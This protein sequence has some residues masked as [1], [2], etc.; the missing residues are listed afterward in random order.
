MPSEWSEIYGQIGRIVVA[1]ETL[2]FNVCNGIYGCIPGDP[3]D[4]TARMIEKYTAG[5]LLTADMTLAEKIDLLDALAKLVLEEE[6][7]AK[8]ALILKRAHSARIKRNNRIHAIWQGIPDFGGSPAI[9]RRHSRLRDVARHGALRPPENM[10]ASALR[11][12][13][14]QIRSVTG[15]LLDF[16]WDERLLLIPPDKYRAFDDRSE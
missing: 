6:K 16:L 4:D 5:T 13:V 9:L 8:L 10:T 1:G 12:D 11:Q 2:D 7:H 15:D 14:E 3:G